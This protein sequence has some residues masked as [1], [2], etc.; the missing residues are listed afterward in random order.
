MISIVC[1]LYDVSYLDR[2]DIGNVRT[3][4]ILKDF[5]LDDAD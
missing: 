4:G 2:G 3:T 5:Y 1:L